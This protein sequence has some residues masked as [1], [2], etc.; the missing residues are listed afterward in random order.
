MPP[1]GA[2]IAWFMSEGKAG[3]PVDKAAENGNRTI[4]ALVTSYLADRKAEMESGNLS[5]A[6]YSSDVYRLDVFATHCERERKSKLADVVTA[7][8][9]GAYRAKQLKALAKGKASAPTAKHNLRTVKALLRWAYK[10]EAIDVLPRVLEG[11]ANVTIPKPVLAFYSVDEIKTQW[12]HA[13]PRQRLYILLA[14]N[15][16]YT[17]ADIATLEHGMVDLAAGKVIRNRHKTEQ[18][19]NA[20]LWPLTSKLLQAEMTD[21]RKSTLMLLGE[22]GNPLVSDKE[23]EAGKPLHIDAINLAFKRVKVKAKM[24][25]DKRGFKHF[26]KTARRTSAKQIRRTSS[27]CS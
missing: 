7:E 20:K 27:Q 17:Q 13:T 22:N 14:L 10:T 15:L 25:G 8:F 4:D 5:A 23:S 24:T 9:L 6:S 16:G 19:Q 12:K 3:L 18:P 26:R 2:D 1:E 11:Y 21:P